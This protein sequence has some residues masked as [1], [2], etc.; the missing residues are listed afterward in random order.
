VNQPAPA[1]GPAPGEKPSPQDLVNQ[2]KK[3]T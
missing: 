1:G 2:N 3:K